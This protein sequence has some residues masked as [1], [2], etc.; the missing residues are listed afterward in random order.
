MTA[1]ECVERCAREQPLGLLNHRRAMARAAH[2]GSLAPNVGHPLGVVES[3]A[4]LLMESRQLIEK[5]W[6]RSHGRRVRIFGSHEPP[7]QALTSRHLLGAGVLHPAHQLVK[8]AGH[9]SLLAVFE[10]VAAFSTILP[11]QDPYPP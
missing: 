9:G 7:P 8:A 6:P 10:Q 1:E 3:G 4:V 5:P 2:F 11:G